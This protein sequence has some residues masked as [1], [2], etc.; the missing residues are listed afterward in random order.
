MLRGEDALQR[1]SQ[2][3]GQTASGADSTD[4][5]QARLKEVARGFDAYFARILLKEM[6]GSV[7]KS[8]LFGAGA[9]GE[10][11]QDMFD[12][13]LAEALSK[14]GGFGIGEMIERDYAASAQRMTARQAVEAYEKQSETR[15][16]L[17]LESTVEPKS[18]G[19]ESDPGTFLPLA[20]DRA[21]AY[22]LEGEATDRA[23]KLNSNTIKRLG[24]LEGEAEK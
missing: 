2:Y 8:S 14:A 19:R 13:H 16:G 10:L 3:R 18:L 21:R 5:E 12:E 24:N 7:L 1:L 11:Y 9:A 15:T 23:I 6:R 4:S 22:S 20:E 17:P